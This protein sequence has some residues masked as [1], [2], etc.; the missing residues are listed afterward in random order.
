MGAGQNQ[1]DV[2]RPGPHTFDITRYKGYVAVAG[3][4]LAREALQYH[5]YSKSFI[6]GDKGYVTRP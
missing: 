1:R 4:R 5:E 3:A 6:A 2:T